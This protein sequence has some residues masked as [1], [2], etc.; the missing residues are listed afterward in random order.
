M[1]HPATLTRRPPRRK[2]RRKPGRSDSLP[3]ADA[4]IGRQVEF[5]ARPGFDE[6]RSGAVVA[7]RPPHQPPRAPAA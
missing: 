1:D 6:R 2:T 3:D 4:L 7:R 5:L